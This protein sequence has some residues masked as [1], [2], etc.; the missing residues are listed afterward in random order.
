NAQ[1]EFYAGNAGKLGDQQMFQPGGGQQG[2]SRGGQS[3][4]GFLNYD[5]EVAGQQWDKLEKAQQV[6]VAKVAPLRVNLPTRGAHYSFAQVLQTEI[7]KP[8]TVRLLAE[9]T[10]VP[11]WT[12]RVGLSVLAFCGLWA[13]MAVVNQRKRACAASRGG[14]S[15]GRL[16][17]VVIASFD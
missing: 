10:K 9:N 3:G 4:N 14:G 2:V 5:P 15:N 12:S 11:S 17:D 1:N 13:V 6:A 7:R 8:M 16:F